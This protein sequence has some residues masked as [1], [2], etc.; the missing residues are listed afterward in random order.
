MVTII[1]KADYISDLLG[2]QE[3]NSKIKYRRLQF[4]E[5]CE[6][7]GVYLAYN[8]LTRHFVQLSFEEW[9]ILSN[10]EYDLISNCLDLVSNWFLVPMDNDDIKLYDQSLKLLNL[11]DQE[12]YINGYT[13]LTTTD[14]NARCFYCYE[15]GIKHIHMTAQTA[16]NVADFIIQNS[17]SKKVSL[18]WF[19]GEP[20][21]NIEPINIITAELTKA[22]IDFNSSMTSN[23]YLFDENTVKT[24]KEF[25]K[26]NHVQITLDGTQ[27]VYNRAKNFVYEDPNPFARVCKNIEMLLDNNIAVKI[28]LNMDIHNCED[29]YELCEY[30]NKRFHNRKK[31][32]VYI[33]LLFDFNNKRSKSQKE[34]LIN[35]ALDL[36]AKLSDMGVLK[37]GLKPTPFKATYCMA[38]NKHYTLINPDGGL[39][40]CE[41]YPNDYLWG[42][43]SNPLYN[44]TAFDE[45]RSGGNHTQNCKT[46]PYYIECIAPDK[47]VSFVNNCDSLDR[48]LR[49]TRMKRA[50]IQAFK[51]N[52]ETDICDQKIC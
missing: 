26:L 15:K 16:H 44:A 14:C 34:F 30:L 19:G 48:K 33:A 9:H 50:M 4:V 51:N 49:S 43:I 7:D 41:H 11:F 13:I 22:G 31:L 3:Y 47:C 40:R 8:M 29:L 27:D 20:L 18:S 23:G 38:D 6:S 12:R 1:K 37:Y 45:W 24:A 35:R 28:R 2:V 32:H 36:E 10:E 46:C 39:G 52:E 5:L 25:W 42:S 21:Y 17:K